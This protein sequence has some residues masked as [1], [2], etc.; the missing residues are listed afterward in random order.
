MATYYSRLTK[1][2]WL[3]TKAIDID[4][5]WDHDFFNF[6]NPTKFFKI[7]TKNKNDMRKVVKDA[8][9][10]DIQLAADCTTKG[11]YGLITNSG[12]AYFLTKINGKWHW[13]SVGGDR[14]YSLNHTNFDSALEKAMEFDDN[15]VLLFDKPQDVFKFMTE[16]KSYLNADEMPKKKAGIPIPAELSGF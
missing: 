3:N 15:K 14:N 13:L 8:D 9:K 6:L 5:S 16:P 12:I 10:V 4:I 11:Y 1:E 2:H 7:I